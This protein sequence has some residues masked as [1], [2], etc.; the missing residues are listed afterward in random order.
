MRRERSLVAD[1]AGK[2]WLSLGLGIASGG[3]N[4]TDRDSTPV[5][6]RITSIS[7]NGKN[8]SFTGQS[9][10]PAGTRSMTFQYSIDSLF[11]PERVR[12]RYRLEGA[13][14][15]WSDDLGRRGAV[16]NNLSPGKYRFRLMASRDGVLWNGPETVYAFSIDPTLWQTW[17]FRT[18]GA[19]AVLLSILLI[20]RLRSTYLARQLNARYQERAGERMRIA[21]DLHDTLLQSF[22][23]LMLR[24]QVVEDLLPDGKAKDQLEESLE[25]ADNA[26]AEARNAV[27]DLRSS[28]TTPHE[29]AEALR[30]LGDELATDD[31]AAFRLVVEGTARDMHPIIRDEFYRI[32]REAVRN[33]FTH[34]RA[35]RIETELTYG[36]S[37]LR[38]RIRDDGQGIPAEFVEEG[39]PGHY[40]LTGMRE[41]ARQIGARLGIWSGTGAGTEIEL[42][43]ASAIAY[44][45]STGRRLFRMFRKKA[46]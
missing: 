29:L 41:R 38:L 33:A 34:A 3:P 17:W 15:D 19:I 44:R 37:E 11:A 16:Y 39:R 13:E 6:A 7:A 36:T 35:H 8:V 46:D 22:Q 2:I 24:L 32:A 28:A 9:I 23:G 31:S 4:L 1:P 5:Q 10:V 26:I 30:A 25:R 18:A 21:R 45:E 43:I 20:I 12:F 42:R 27:Q 40:G 14:P